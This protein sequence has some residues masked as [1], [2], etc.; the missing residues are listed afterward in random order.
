MQEQLDER[1]ID[2]SRSTRGLVEGE[3]GFS[4]GARQKG[5]RDQTHLVPLKL[6]R[7]DFGASANSVDGFVDIG[8]NT[9]PRFELVRGEPRDSLLADKDAQAVLEIVLE[10]VKKQRT[11]VQ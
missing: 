11:S 3:Q 5:L 1:L 9:V 7:H 4:E 2:G 8:P 10:S 6:A